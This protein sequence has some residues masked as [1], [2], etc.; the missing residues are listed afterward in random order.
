[1]TSNTRTMMKMIM[2]TTYAAIIP[3]LS[4]EDDMLLLLPS[5]E[6]LLDVGVMDIFDISVA[7]VFD[8]K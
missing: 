8:I 2:P 1:M 3:E 7:I 6:D 5:V 4:S